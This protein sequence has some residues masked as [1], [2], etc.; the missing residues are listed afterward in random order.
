MVAASR[1]SAMPAATV[2]SSS[3]LSKMGADKKAELA[4]QRAAELMKEAA[5]S[6]DSSDSDAPAAKST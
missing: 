2:G 4:K 6:S 1:S 3:L 5:G